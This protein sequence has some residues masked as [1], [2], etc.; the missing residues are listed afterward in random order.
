VDIAIYF[1][2]QPCLVTVKVDDKPS[3]DL[4]PSKMDSQLVRRRNARL[5]HI[6]QQKNIGKT[7]DLFAEISIAINL[8]LAYDMPTT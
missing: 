5:D 8:K 4:L 6:H 3:N 7:Y 1:N 2:D